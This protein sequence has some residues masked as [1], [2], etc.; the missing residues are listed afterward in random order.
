[1][2]VDA[3][4]VL[5]LCVRCKGTIEFHIVVGGT[6]ESYIIVDHHGLR[7]SRHSAS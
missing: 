4:F 3:S 1:M 2:Y 7:K 6:I 5:H